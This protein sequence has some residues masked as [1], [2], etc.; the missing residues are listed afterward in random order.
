MEDWGI[1]LFESLSTKSKYGMEK[2][3]SEAF[4]DYVWHFSTS[5]LIVM[6]YYNCDIKNVY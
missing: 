4:S 3:S 6:I 5:A 2:C 1:V